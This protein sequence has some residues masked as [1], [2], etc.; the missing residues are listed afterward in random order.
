MK[1]L[2]QAMVLIAVANSKVSWP[3][4]GEGGGVSGKR[5]VS[6][7]TGGS[8]ASKGWCPLVG[9]GAGAVMGTYGRGFSWC[10]TQGLSK[11]VDNGLIT[12]I[13]TLSQFTF[14]SS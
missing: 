5:T 4:G 10:I 14:R 13:L 9:E 8:Q 3:W 7:L 1:S 12:T 2:P 6:A 11:L